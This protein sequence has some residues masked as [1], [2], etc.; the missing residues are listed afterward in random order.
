MLTLH[1]PFEVAHKQVAALMRMSSMPLNKG[2]WHDFM[3]MDND[4]IAMELTRID[5]ILFSG[6]RP[7]DLIRHINNSGEARASSKGLETIDRMVLHFNHLASWL[8]QMILLRDKP[9]HRA[10]MMEKCMLIAWVS[11]LHA[12]YIVNTDYVETPPQEE[13]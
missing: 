4:V 7:R 11:Y 3:E 8:G 6:I 1:N 2:H 9:K 5:W 10:R 12:H 13:L